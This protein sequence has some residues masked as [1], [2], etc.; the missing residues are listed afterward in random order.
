[1]ENT[2]NLKLVV[3]GEGGVGKTSIINSFLGR[4]IP[5]SYMP[6]IGSI[7]NRKEYNIKTKDTII[8]LNIWDLGGQRSFNPFNPTYYANIDLALLVFDLTRLKETLINIKKDFLEKIRKYSEE[9]LYILV[10]NKSDISS[11]DTHFKNTIK[12]YLDE[13]DRFFF[14]SAKTKENINEC[15]EFLIHKYLQRAEILSPDT[16]AEHTTKEFMKY[17]GK[18]EEDLKNKLITF[19]SLDSYS[20]GLDHIS[21][22]KIKDPEKIED[23]ELKYYEFIQQELN[24]TIRQKS[25]IFDQFLIDLSELDKTLKHIKK[26]NIK[27]IDG[28]IDNLKNLLTISKDDLEEKIKLIYK[29][30][31]EENELTIISS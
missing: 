22:T 8:K 26:S 9:P 1:M 24:K 25:D 10:G 31:R 30:N 20:I 15:F 19:P 14:L 17:I 18:S 4:E 27:I 28:V 13:K 23:K 29:L 16:V 5:N 12:E 11:T 6:T 2:I 21:P 3:L 7:T